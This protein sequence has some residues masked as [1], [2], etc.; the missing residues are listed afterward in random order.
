MAG[1]LVVWPRNQAV[2]R[3]GDPIPG[4]KLF[5][6]AANTST[7]VPTYRDAELLTPNT[8]PVIANAAGVFPAIFLDATSYK[9]VLKDADDTVIWSEPV[10]AATHLTSASLAGDVKNF[11]GDPTSPVTAVA[12]PAGATF[13][14]CHAGTAV[15]NLDAANLAAGTYVLEAMLMGSGGA[16]I[17]LA[18]VNLSDAPDVAIVEVASASTTGARVQSGAITFPAAGAAKD[19]AIKAKVNAG[20]GFAWTISIKRID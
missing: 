10:V 5:V 15:W 9:L 19:L 8:N 17:T 11:G 18:L 16:T 7:P 1:S 3:Q 2:D 6:F 12:Y 4:G 14:K 13:D 20:A